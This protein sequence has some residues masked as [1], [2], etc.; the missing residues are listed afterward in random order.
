VG[1]TDSDGWDPIVRPYKEAYELL[2]VAVSEAIGDGDFSDVI[3]V[4][5]SSDVLDLRDIRARDVVEKNS[6]LLPG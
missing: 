3:L 1:V 4:D 5:E 2:C 6:C